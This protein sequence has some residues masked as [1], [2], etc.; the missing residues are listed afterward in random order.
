[1]LRFQEAVHIPGVYDLEVD[2]S[3]SMAA[4]CAEMIRKRL[5]AGI[6]EPS[7]FEKLATTA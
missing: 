1:V 7:A 2:T 3:K 4:E 5:E 6:L